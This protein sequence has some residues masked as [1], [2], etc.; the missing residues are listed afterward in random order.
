MKRTLMG[1]GITALFVIAVYSMLPGLAQNPNQAL[2][3]TS[4]FGMIEKLQVQAEKLTGVALKQNQRQQLDEKRLDSLEREC[5]KQREQVTELERKVAGMQKQ[6]T[7]LH[8]K[9]ADK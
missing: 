3:P 7:I 6:I 2:T 1:T 4:L 9:K 5:L 8:S